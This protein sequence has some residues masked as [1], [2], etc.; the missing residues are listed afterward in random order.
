MTPTTV[1]HAFLPDVTRVCGIR[2]YPLTCAHLLS[3][4]KSGAW[5]A[6]TGEAPAS[7]GATCAALTILSTPAYACLNT[8]FPPASSSSWEL[9]R[10]GAPEALPALRAHV[11]AA[12]SA[13]L[14][15]KVPGSETLLADPALGLVAEITDFLMH[16]YA[17]PLRHALQ[18]PLAQAFV[19]LAAAAQRNGATFAAPHYFRR[20]ETETH[21]QCP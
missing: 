19:L 12:F 20:D 2:L 10:Y 6:L 5:P 16:E 1:I 13:Y 8:A 17:T 15:A 11:C 18:T 3:L 7:R 21:H 14:P 4:A 9:V